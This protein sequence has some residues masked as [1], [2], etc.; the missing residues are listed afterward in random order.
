MI[1]IYIYV[2]YHII[3]FINDIYDIYDIMYKSCKIYNISCRNLLDELSS[4][5]SKHGPL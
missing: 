5:V 2:Y 3:Y 1:Y 4:N